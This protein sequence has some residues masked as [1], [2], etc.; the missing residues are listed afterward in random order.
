MFRTYL[1]IS[2]IDKFFSTRGGLQGKTIAIWGLAFKPKTDDIRESA[3]IYII[4]HLLKK[5]A[6][7]RA[8]D[9]KG[10]DNMKKVFGE[11]VTFC[12]G[13][14]EALEGADALALVTEW[15]TFKAPD[16]NEIKSLLK[17]PVIFDGRNIYDPDMLKSLGFQ[18]FGIGRE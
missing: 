3:A 17:T 7:V 18:Y 13:K 5:G 4:D 9:P 2:K 8:F 15:D 11:K 16:F 1:Q 14:Y 12:S 6:S 10:S